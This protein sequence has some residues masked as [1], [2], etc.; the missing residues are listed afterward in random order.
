MSE[1]RKGEDQ[2]I[3]A[4]TA[5]IR[6]G[7][8]DHPRAWAGSPC[9]GRVRIYLALGAAPVRRKHDFGAFEV[10]GHRLFFKIDYY[11]PD[12]QHGSEDPAD[13][14]KTVR[15]LTLMLAEEY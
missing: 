13:P 15:V 5:R 7:A 2:D 8:A 1:R 9:H 11:A 6:R 12:M 10:E 4:E 14:T 3:R